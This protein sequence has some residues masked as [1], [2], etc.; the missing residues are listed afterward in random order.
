MKIRLTTD[1]GF[2]LVELIIAMAIFATTLSIIVASFVS[3]V[4][5]QRTAASQRATLEDGRRILDDMASEI[6]SSNFAGAEVC[7]DS[8]HITGTSGDS[9]L[10]FSSGVYYYAAA[11]GQLIKASISGVS[12]CADL[13]SPTNPTGL[14]VPAG[15]SITSTNVGVPANGL[16]L[17]QV[18]DFDDVLGQKSITVEIDLQLQGAGNVHLH[19]NTAITTRGGGA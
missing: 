2:T 1:R 7:P 11:S 12:N 3:L 10:L 8:L 18:N 14:V 13:K 4:R 17:A 9:L 19:L 5:I 15:D 6:R 16:G